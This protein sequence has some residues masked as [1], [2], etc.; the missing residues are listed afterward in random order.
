LIIDN[1]LA[2]PVAPAIDLSSRH[3]LE[4]T[5]PFSIL[6]EAYKAAIKE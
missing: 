5:L 2:A 4:R 3:P 1:S 6:L